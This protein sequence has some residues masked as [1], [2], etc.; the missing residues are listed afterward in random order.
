M[1]AI[2]RELLQQQQQQQ[3]DA[4]KEVGGR[5]GFETVREQEKHGGGERERSGKCKCS[6]RIQG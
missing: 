4:E 1:C 5:E 2:F 6:V 3:D